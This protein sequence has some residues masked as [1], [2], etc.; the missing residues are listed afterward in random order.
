MGILIDDASYVYG[1][2]MSVLYNTTNPESTLKKKL[3]SIAYHLCRESVAMDEMRVGYVKT[4]DNFADL[5]TKVQP[6]G[7]RRER[8]LSQLMWDIYA[9]K[10]K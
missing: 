5:M 3:N 6:K 10:S 1:D 2:N 9:S 4:D 7:E 8:L